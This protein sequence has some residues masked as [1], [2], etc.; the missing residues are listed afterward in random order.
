M[1]FKP[2]A[3]REEFAIPD[4]I[5]PVALLVMGYPSES[6]KPFPGHSYFKP[7]E[8]IVSYNEF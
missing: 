5:E 7:M 8:E 6:A 4:H 3:V 2:E 1:H